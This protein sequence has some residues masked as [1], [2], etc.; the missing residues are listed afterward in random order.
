[1]RIYLDRQVPLFLRTFAKRLRGYRAIGYVRDVPGFD[2]EEERDESGLV[3]GEETKSG[4]AENRD[5][6]PARVRKRRRTTTRP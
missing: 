6:R 5:R 4:K 3:G 1:V 2:R